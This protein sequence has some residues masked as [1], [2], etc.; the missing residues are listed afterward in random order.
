MA[1]ILLWQLSIPKY[2]PRDD[3]DHYFFFMSLEIYCHSN[4]RIKTRLNLKK[5]GKSREDFSNTNGTL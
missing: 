1:T 2:S 5:N 3:F 4:K